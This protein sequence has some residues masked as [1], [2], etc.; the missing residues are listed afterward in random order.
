MADESEQNRGRPGRGDVAERVTQL[1]L[2][3][4]LEGLNDIDRLHEFM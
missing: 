2:L 1:A 4:I 3:I